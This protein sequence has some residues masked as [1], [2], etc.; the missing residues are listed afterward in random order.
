[1][2][3]RLTGATIIVGFAIL[4]ISVLLNKP[5][6]DSDATF[7]NKTDNTRQTIS[8]SIPLQHSNANSSTDA[9]RSNDRPALL[10]DTVDVPVIEQQSPSPSV[11]EYTKSVKNTEN[12]KPTPYSTAPKIAQPNSS[13]TDIFID[14]GGWTVR[15]GTFSKTE[16]V[17]TISVLL[18]K[19]GFD[20]RHSKV[21]T[22]LGTATR[23]WL[24]PYAKK[25]TA[26]KVSTRLR[27]ITG[28]KG[29]VTKQS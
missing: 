10:N 19:N 23:I 1:M 28:E 3:Y 24:G 25:K 6:I 17:D 21:Q 16:N 7:G 2:K 18:K 29:Y 11:T 14:G 12:K 8:L 15:V 9:G 22:T 4:M 20:A 5:E 13:S 27:T 26:E